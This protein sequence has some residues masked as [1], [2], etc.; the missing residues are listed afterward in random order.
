[1]LL[2]GLSSS[3][4][5]VWCVGSVVGRWRMNCTSFT[6]TTDSD[7]LE[8]SRQEFA[9]ASALLKRLAFL[10]RASRGPPAVDHHPVY[11]PRGC[12][13]DFSRLHD[14][15]VWDASINKVTVLYCWWLGEWCG[16]LLEDGAGLPAPRLLCELIFKSRAKNLKNLS[17][18]A[19]TLAGAPTES[20]R[21]GTG[22]TD[23][24]NFCHRLLKSLVDFSATRSF[25]S[26]LVSLIP[27]GRG[28]RA[29]TLM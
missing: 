29:P 28:R 15:R 7:R 14:L 17:P 1:M 9:P 27:H 24:N 6:R 3:F 5:L 10:I 12:L 25:V 16:H 13:C 4:E 21:L 20:L 11:H 19:R 18:E 22:K 2:K 26:F 8:V 23:L